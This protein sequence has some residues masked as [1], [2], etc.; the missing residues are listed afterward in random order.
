MT[1]P[2]YAFI[3]SQNLNLGVRS[4]GWKIDYKRF[5]LYLR[6]KYNVQE[7]YLFVGM[8]ADNQE[9]YTALQ[10]AGFILVFKPTVRYFEN[11]KETVKGNV[12]AELVLYAAAKTYDQYNKAL[13]ISGDGD[14]YCLAEYLEENNK[15][16]HI[17]VPNKIYSKLL[18]RFTKHIVRLDLL[19]SRLEYRYVPHKNQPKRSVETLGRTG[20]A[21]RSSGRSKP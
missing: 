16:L 18:K 19:R 1:R 17:M 10:Q 9:L 15:L 14:F 5:R 2:N 12:D 13:I 11:G 8:I 20:K 7:A 3:D 4:Q 21:P 6:N